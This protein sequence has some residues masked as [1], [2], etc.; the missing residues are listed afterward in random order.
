M[1]DD[2]VI[3]GGTE[4]P[5]GTEQTHEGGKRVGIP[6]SETQSDAGGPSVSFTSL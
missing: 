5:L 3:S 2:D 1:T 4:I 6:V